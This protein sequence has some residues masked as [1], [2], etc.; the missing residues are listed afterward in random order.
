MEGATGHPVCALLFKL[1][2]ILDY[3]DNVRLALQ[4][5]DECL[6]ITHCAGEQSRLF[7]CSRNAPAKSNGRI[8]FRELLIELG[9]P[10]VIGFG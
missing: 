9:I 3:A 1:H 7:W 2:I 8:A 4:I 6:G 10:F 5:V